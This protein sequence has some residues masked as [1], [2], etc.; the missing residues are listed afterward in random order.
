MLRDRRLAAAQS[1]FVASRPPAMQH[2]PEP[3]LV[4][5]QDTIL[6][7][8]QGRFCSLTALRKA[9]HATADQIRVSIR[10][11]TDIFA[12]TPCVSFPS[13]MLRIIILV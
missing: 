11:A 7:A 5:L 9:V 8:A 12:M 3:E 1:D 4:A 2:L 10:R 6:G 13:A